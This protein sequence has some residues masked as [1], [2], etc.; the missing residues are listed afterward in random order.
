MAIAQAVATRVVLEV[1]HGRL[2]A[3]DTRTMNQPGD[4]MRRTVFFA[5]SIAAAA[6]MA[7]CG[8]GTA[9]DETLVATPSSA[10]ATPTKSGDGQA[11]TVPPPA[12]PSATS[13][14]TTAVTALETP[15]SAIASAT[16]T[17]GVSQ[18]GAP[19]E[20]QPPPSPTAKP[21]SGNPLSAAIGV[22]GTARYFWSPNSLKIAP[23]GSVTVSWSGGAAHDLSVPGLGF[24]S[25]TK[26]SD[27]HTLT[28]PNTGT[29]EIICVIHDDTMRGKVI[30]E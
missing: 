21:S 2:L 20:T 15:T 27:S 9:G 5:I 29:F 19:A 12:R 22:T 28:F 7:A 4:T 17:P 24:Q 26:V 14:A 1:V 18:G 3:P 16:A 11:T 23:G 8:G 25:G 10:A 13:T 6:L 30:V